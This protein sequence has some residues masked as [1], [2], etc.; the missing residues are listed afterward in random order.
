MRGWVGWPTADGR[1]S[2]YPP[3]LGQVHDRVS[4]PVKD[5]RSTIVDWTILLLLLY[6]L[7]THVT[8]WQHMQRIDELCSQLS[9]GI[10]KYQSLATLFPCL[11][12]ARETLVQC[13]WMSFVTPRGLHGNQSQVA[14]A[15]V[16][17]LSHRSAAAAYITL[18]CLCSKKVSHLMFMLIA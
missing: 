11:L 13:W 2:G 16:Y 3:A 17:H 14:L 7:V 10:W 12:K 4:S 8:R 9:D 5:R 18:Y 6:T 1:I 15:R